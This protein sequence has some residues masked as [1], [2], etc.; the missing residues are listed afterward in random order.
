MLDGADSQSK[1][2]DDVIGGGAGAGRPM[3]R[4]G[5]GGSS[6]LKGQRCPCR[7]RAPGRAGP[8]RGRLR[9]NFYGFYVFMVLSRGYFSNRRCG[10][11]AAKAWLVPVGIEARRALRGGR[12]VRPGRP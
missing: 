8:P 7:L 1:G 10:N 2:R 5:G 9:F 4:R 6:S 3:G 11:G 12:G